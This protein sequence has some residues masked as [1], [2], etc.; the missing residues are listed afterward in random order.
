ME[1]QS[2]VKIENRNGIAHSL[3]GYQYSW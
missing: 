3:V 1:T 2:L